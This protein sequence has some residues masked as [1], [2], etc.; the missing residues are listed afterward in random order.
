MTAVADIVYRSSGALW[1]HVA[2]GARNAIGLGK[3]LTTALK[4]DCHGQVGGAGGKGEACSL[5]DKLLSTRS[6]RSSSAAG[7]ISTIEGLL[8]VFGA[9]R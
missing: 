2:R 7:F 1:R 3:R 8:F 6:R 4:L 5:P 9:A